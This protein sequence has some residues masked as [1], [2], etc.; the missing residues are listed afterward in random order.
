MRFGFLQKHRH[1]LPRPLYLHKQADKGESAQ[2]FSRKDCEI[3]RSGLGDVQEVRIHLH[4]HIWS[5]FACLPYCDRLYK[6]AYFVPLQVLKAKASH[7]PI[8]PDHNRPAKGLMQNSSN[9]KVC[10]P[11]KV[12]APQQAALQA[13]DI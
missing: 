4:W 5:A 3:H 2:V 10:S 11:L 12:S 7:S 9:T 1:G 8:T 6:A 13:S